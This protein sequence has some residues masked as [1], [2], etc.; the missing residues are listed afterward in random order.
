MAPKRTSCAC[1]R[2]GR[3]LSL[4]GG[5]LGLLLGV[6][7]SAL[8]FLS[9]E[10]QTEQGMET[11]SEAELSVVQLK[12]LFQSPRSDRR[13]LKI[14]HNFPKDTSAHERVLNDLKARGFGGVVCNVH[15]DNYLQSEENWKSFAHAVGLAKKMRMTLWLYDEKGYPSGAA[16]GLV[17]DG[18]PEWEA[19]G[20][21]CV[22]ATSDG[23]PVEL[24]LPEGRLVAA[25]AFPTEGGRI[26]LRRGA[27]LA[28]VIGDERVL[29]W[30]PPQGRWTVLAFV[31]QRLFEGTHAQWNL[32]EKRA[33]PNL[34]M[35]EPIARFLE[36][37]HEEYARRFPDLAGTFE[38]IF[39]DEPSLMSVFLRPQP[40]PVIPWSPAL[41]RRFREKAGRD[42][43]PLLPALFVNAG[44]ES[45]R[46]RCEFW[47]LIGEMVSDAYFGQI[48]DWCRAHRIAST[49]HL[50]WEEDLAY[51]VGFYGD[52][53]RCV[54]RLDLPGIDCLTSKPA[55][56]PFHIAKLIGSIAHL[57]GCGKTM[58]ETSDHVQRYRPPGDAR[59]REAVS[60]AEIKGTCNLLYVCG[61]N[62][63]TSYYSWANLSTEE[64]RQINEYIGRLGVMLTGGTHV[65]DI[66][67]L[68]PT[69]SLW[70]NF[71]P[72]AHGA[73][74]SAEVAAINRTFREVSAALFRNRLDYDYLDSAALRSAKLVGDSFEVGRERY[75]ILVLPYVDT[76]PLDVWRKVTEFWK[77]GGVVVAV[78]TMPRNH[79]LE[80]P[81][82]EVMRL[83]GEVFGAPSEDAV[84]QVRT[85][86]SE[87]GGAGAFIPSSEEASISTIIG[88]LREP[89]CATGS[90][91]SP[92]RYTHRRVAGKEVY[93]LINDSP[94][95]VED[96]VICHA[97]GRA[98]LW[99]PS[100]GEVVPL[101]GSTVEE[102]RRTRFRIRI[103]G[104][105]SRFVTFDG[106]ARSAS[107]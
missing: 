55:E 90:S 97:V 69:E 106:P 56:I 73:T 19:K 62:T 103:E 6:L 76:L 41:P 81:S 96:E 39:T 95:E 14:V 93:F 18:H 36:L 57:R 53:Y 107:N 100:T 58:S 68:Y 94:D 1:C 67:V 88:Q 10:A 33:Y 3:L 43:V 11:G 46:V 80:F 66:A 20:V 104:F 102:G 35:R 30:S 99:N 21:A 38:A 8:C 105:G 92:L 7:L 15:F 84:R 64:Q 28:T 51:H 52:F 2:D 98:E 34:L 12:S 23:S 25:F 22:S 75:R 89:D 29:R 31:E 17:L 70:A 45:G 65:C 26:D 101:G 54:E 60:A 86:R 91:S 16:G 49:G 71:V 37:T 47:G 85:R 9:R 82:D 48:Q 42:L 78:G 83:T 44:A 4:R 61:I 13:I 32:H 59:P 27:D 50:L 87:R 63:T 74:Q 5:L 72:A 24:K 79:P 77:E 40:H